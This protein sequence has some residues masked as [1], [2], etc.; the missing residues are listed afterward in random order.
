M[1]APQEVVVVVGATTK[2]GQDLEL[3]LPAASVRAKLELAHVVTFGGQLPRYA[4]TGSERRDAFAFGHKRDGCGL[5][6]CPGGRDPLIMA[7]SSSAVTRKRRRDTRIRPSVWCPCC[8][9]FLRRGTQHRHMAKRRKEHLL[10]FERD[11]EVLQLELMRLP[12]QDDQSDI[13]QDNHQYEQEIPNSEESDEEESEGGEDCEDEE[14]Q[15]E[16][17][18][19]D[20]ISSSEDSSE[21][22][23]IREKLT[24][25]SE[26]M[27]LLWDL[28]DKKTSMCET[29]K[30]FEGQLSVLQ[31]FFEITSH[32]AHEDAREDA[33][34]WSFFPKTWFSARSM[35]REDLPRHIKI[36]I[37]S[38]N[39]CMMFYKET[40][41]HRY[42]AKYYTGLL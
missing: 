14:D 25:E 19:K 8:G 5:M 31:R 22:D 32:E 12:D 28:I 13:D 27:R 11:S 3:D 17:R 42:V 24:P 26:A 7:T 2:S 18:E 16:E 6:S 9:K 35:I 34:E 33:R 4:E 39:Y 10:Q 23:E 37:C 15:K 36:P 21:I 30:T 41:L 1:H 29:Q 20:N 40:V 38:S